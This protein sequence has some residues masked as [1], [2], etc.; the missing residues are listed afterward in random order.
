VGSRLKQFA[1][2]LLAMALAVG[3]VAWASVLI[4]D[5]GVDCG[6]AWKAAYGVKVPELNAGV[7]VPRGAD[8][9]ELN[10]TN[11]HW[12]TYCA[13]QGRLRVAESGV[14]AAGALV[15]AFLPLLRR[16][17]RGGPDVAIV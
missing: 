15:I 10:N 6:T 1:L 7:H 17:R 3:A 9:I 14:L 4:T 8:G 16:R 11:T 5:K 2:T 12:V 13:G